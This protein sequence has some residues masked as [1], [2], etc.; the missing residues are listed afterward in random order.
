MKL[1]VPLALVALSGSAAAQ[2]ILETLVSPDPD[3]VAYTPDR[4]VVVP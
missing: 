2:T 4:L 1:L 3:Y